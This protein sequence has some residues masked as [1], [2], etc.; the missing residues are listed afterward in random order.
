MATTMTWVNAAP[1]DLEYAG[2]AQA[3]GVKAPETVK[4][5]RKHGEV[6]E[7]ARNFYFD[8]GILKKLLMWL[9]GITPRRNIL[10][11]GAAGTGKS[12]T[13]LE[14]AAQVNVPVFQMACS[15]RTRFAH[16]VG[17]R[18]LVNDE[19]RWVDGPL[20]R[21]MR[22][23]GI[24]LMD[25]I[26]RMDAGEQM[27]LASV[28]DARSSITIPDT[29]EVVSP[30]PHF[31]VAATGNSTGFGDETGAYPGEKIASV[32]FLDRFQK[33]VLPSLPY[34]AEVKLV[35][36]VAPSLP[37]QI[38]ERMVKLANEV[39]KASV[40]AGG[41]LVTT[42]SP[43][44]VQIWAATAVAY[45]NAGIQGSTLEALSDTVLNGAPASDRGII[46]ELFD[47]WL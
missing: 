36:S 10:I 31:R 47:S 18:E 21:A 9:Y 13:I 12:A 4:F 46:H 38:V 32:A 42:L 39:R 15:G 29:G 25:E 7:A 16:M 44:A 23:G 1:A 30:H 41:T 5:A 20:V 11:S 45:Q 34:E 43:R 19:T 8:S 33:L 40:D 14:L 2:L 27:N 28:L 17:G 3:F 37:A 22:E 26:T 35:Q 24:F 6:R